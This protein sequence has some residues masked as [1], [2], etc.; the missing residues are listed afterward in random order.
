MYPVSLTCIYWLE[1]SREINTGLPLL[2]GIKRGDVKTPWAKGA[3]SY[4]AARG[5][6]TPIPSAP[7]QQGVLSSLQPPRF[8]L[9]RST[10]PLASFKVCHV[11][12][13]VL[14]IFSS[15]SKWNHFSLDQQYQGFRFELW[16]HIC[17]WYCFSWSPSL[18]QDSFQV[19]VK[20]TN[21]KLCFYCNVIN[22]SIF[23]PRQLVR[24]TN[25]FWMNYF[26]DLVLSKLLSLEGLKTPGTTS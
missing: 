21:R 25:L 19:N 2:H 15:F 7:S 9:L 23:C 4:R 8:T 12:L 22:G 14:N 6:S 3:Q 26:T 13:I 20:P 5:N 11:F 24:S 1:G 10:F 16:T 17:S 18:P